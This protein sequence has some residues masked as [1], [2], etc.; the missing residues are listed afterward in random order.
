M[1]VAEEEQKGLREPP[2][3]GESRVDCVVGLPAG[4]RDRLGGGGEAEGAE[5]AREPGREELGGLVSRLE[6]D[7]QARQ[8]EMLGELLGRG[9][10][11][12]AP[13]RLH[14]PRTAGL[15]PPDKP[16]PVDMV[17]RELPHDAS[18]DREVKA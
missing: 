8:P 2:Q 9:G 11:P 1:S 17:P 3:R 5:R 15:E 6:G 16:R 7:R 18:L 13:A 4:R 10:P 14:D 12:V